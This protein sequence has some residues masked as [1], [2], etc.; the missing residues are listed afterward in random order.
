MKIQSDDAGLVIRPRQKADTSSI[1]ALYNSQEHDHLPQ[2]VS[3]YEAE[4][5]LTKVDEQR[6][7]WVAIYRGVWAGYCSFYPAWWTGD[8]NTYSVE[9]R[10][11]DHFSRQ[12]IGTRLFEQMLSRLRVQKA[13]RLLCWLREDTPSGLTF[14]KRWG[15]SETGQRMQDYLLSVPDVALEPLMVAEKRLAQEGI[16]LMTLAEAEHWGEPFLRHLYDLCNPVEESEA[17][18]SLRTSFE[19]WQEQTL[20][21]EGVMPEAYWVAV[22]GAMPVGVTFLKLSGAENAENDYT[23]VAPAYQGRGIATALKGKAIAW[24]QNAGVLW[25]HTSCEV[26]N[27][28]MI[29]IN[30]RLG[31]RPGAMRREVVYDIA[32]PPER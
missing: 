11:D 18:E 6:E 27:A 17:E 21:A 29:G 12:G 8:P 25:F 20:K 22:E 2:S 23:A 26:E 15:F 4:H 19:L 31:Y 14:A 5:P 7:Q 13:D 3:R 30:T 9:I 24:A 32:P 1:V 10:V 28:P 16:A